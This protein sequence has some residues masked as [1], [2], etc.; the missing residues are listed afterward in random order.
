[1]VSLSILSVG[2]A[3]DFLYD[4]GSTAA[5]I[6]FDPAP[7]SQFLLNTHTLS[8]IHQILVD[9]ADRGFTTAGPVLL[10]WSFIL[11][12][13]YGRVYANTAAQNDENELRRFDRPS[14]IDTDVTLAPDPYENL[15]RTIMQ[16]LNDQNPIEYLIQTAINHCH[17]LETLNGFGLRLGNTPEAFFS[18]RTG[19]MMRIVILDL[20]KSSS[21]SGIDY[22]AEVM[23]PLLSSLFGGRNYWYLVDSKELN[24]AFD[25]ITAFLEDQE[26]LAAFLEN[27]MSRY[28]YES[29]PFLRIIHVISACWSCLSD[30]K[31]AIT[32]LEAIQ[33]F[34]YQLPDGFIDYETTQEEDNNNNVLL[35]RAVNL[36][37]PRTR[38][39]RP[40][41]SSALTLV[42]RDFCG[43]APN[44]RMSH[45][46]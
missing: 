9:A 5:P 31:S 39:I 37:E 27:A 18:N 42:D 46:S 41:R 4:P 12:A 14:S 34:T 21:I 6:T 10:A 28:P 29:L 35:K 15:V 45:V 19:A 7:K 38:S 1:M 33:T 3:L 13:L 23:E 44:P 30:P 16:G 43:K 25:P 8:E 24:K 36:F 17:A 40:G 22:Q 2:S 26:L 20:M 11:K 32:I